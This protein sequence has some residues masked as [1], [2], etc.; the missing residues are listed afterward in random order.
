MILYFDVPLLPLCVTTKKNPV[1][2]F[3]QV[4]KSSL[5]LIILVECH[6]NE[7]LNLIIIA[8]FA[9]KEKEVYRRCI[10]LRVQM[11]SAYVV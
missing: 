1:P 7:I 8:F 6:G 2:Y 4:S 3:C 5:F 11:I 9:I 10:Y